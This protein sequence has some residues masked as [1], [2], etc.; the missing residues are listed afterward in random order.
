[1][2]NL[3]T[4]LVIVAAGYWV[5]LIISRKKRELSEKELYQKEQFLKDTQSILKTESPSYNKPSAPIQPNTSSPDSLYCTTVEQSFQKQGFTITDSVKADGIDFIGL[6]DKELLLIRCEN[7]L[8]E[9]TI[10]DLKTFIADCA[11]YIDKNPIFEGRSSMRIY[12]TNCPITE[13]AQEFIRNNP[14][15]LRLFTED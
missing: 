1:M 5:M 15:T 6:K 11:V 2:A 3:L 14:S 9:I 13:E 8:K 12:A 10:S 7:R 4:L